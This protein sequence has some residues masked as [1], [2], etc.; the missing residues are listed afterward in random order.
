[1]ATKIIKQDILLRSKNFTVTK[2]QFERDNKVYTKDIIER[3]DVVVILPLNEKNELYLISQYRDAFEK[4]LLEVVAGT[5]DDISFS[6]LDTAKRELQEEAGLTAK[7]W[8]H[9]GTFYSSAS[10]IGNIYVFLAEE[11]TEGEQQL[12]E[13]EEIS[14]VKV[15]FSEAVKKAIGG[16]IPVG[17]HV[18]AILLLD[19]V[20]QLNTV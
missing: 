2:K 1:M 6:P 19:K 10:I 12:D 11:L 18:G 7:K 14:L 4:T 8:I 16:E 9:L 15:P 17:M 20:R 13:D 5:R 3:D